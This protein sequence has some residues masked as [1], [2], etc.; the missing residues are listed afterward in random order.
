[1]LEKLEGRQAEQ[2]H[3]EKRGLR[4]HMY[5]PPLR[6]AVEIL[7][8]NIVEKGFNAHVELD[9]VPDP[10]PGEIKVV[11]WTDGGSLSMRADLDELIGG[12]TQGVLFLL[13]GYANW[14]IEAPFEDDGVY[15][16]DVMSAKSRPLTP[17]PA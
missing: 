5:A 6:E 13:R 14:T 3:L 15:Q 9:R 2:V 10:R 1:F 16:F 4:F 12:D 7:I 17:A 8:Q 11:V